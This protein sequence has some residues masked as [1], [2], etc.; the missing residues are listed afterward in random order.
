MNQ[1]ERKFITATCKNRADA[2]LVANSQDKERV[3]KDEFENMIKGTIL[4]MPH[5]F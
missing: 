4:K 3:G 2:Y 1:E 5:L